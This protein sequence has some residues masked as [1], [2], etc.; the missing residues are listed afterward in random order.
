MGKGHG[1]Q[2]EELLL[3]DKTREEFIKAGEINW[4]YD[5]MGF[6]DCSVVKN[7]SGSTFDPWVRKI[8]GTRK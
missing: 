7:L 6:R 3:L 1:G 5:Q 4:F 2:E 8:L